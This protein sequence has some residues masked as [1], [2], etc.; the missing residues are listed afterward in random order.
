MGHQWVSVYTQLPKIPVTAVY[1]VI[2]HNIL[3]ATF[4]VVQTTATQ[5]GP[6]AHLIV[7]GDMLICHIHICRCVE[8]NTQDMHWSF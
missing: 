2:K 8:K 5:N 7:T 3:L 4:T 1:K 6:F